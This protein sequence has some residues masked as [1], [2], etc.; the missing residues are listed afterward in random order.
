MFGALVSLTLT[1][2][3]PISAQDPG[4]NTSPRPTK[5]I[6]REVVFSSNLP[7]EKALDKLA[8]AMQRADQIG[9]KVG[10]AWALSTSGRF[11][12]TS[13]R[14]VKALD[15]YERALAIYTELKDARSVGETQ[16]EIG[17]VDLALGQP[18]KAEERFQLALPIL[19]ACKALDDEAA[20]L[21]DL[22]DTNIRLG[23]KDAA[24]DFFGK[25]LKIQRDVSDAT[26]EFQ[27]L[28]KIGAVYLDLKQYKK[29]LDC[30]QSVAKISG[31]MDGEEASAATS[32]A[33]LGIAKSY[34]GLG[35]KT[36]AVDAYAKVRPFLVG[37]DLKE[38][39]A[40]THA[41]L[42]EL[43]PLVRGKYLY[44]AG[45]AFTENGQ[46]P[47]GLDYLNQ[48][49]PLRKG[50]DKALT[51]IAIGNIYAQDFKWAQSI[52]WFKQALSLF[53]QA[54][55]STGQIE[56]LAGLIGAFDQLHQPGEVQKYMA[57]EKLIRE[58]LATAKR[59]G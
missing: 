36:Q 29:S 10:K 19:T 50:R 22:G 49:L 32:N 16:K 47:T 11:A 39:K 13:D 57:Q 48:A 31:Y 58:R 8:K 12:S 45:L 35:E 17:E 28:A 3:H 27:T 2:I 38:A 4:P 5:E 37:V 15:F 43:G 44:D 53:E 51:L 14:R 52:V 7:V 42:F 20:T 24:L 46:K 1:L 25:A 30:F 9:D 18:T 6:L 56:A 33:L 41:L 26:R 40:A 21:S 54:K 34:L 23:R 59:G 55:D